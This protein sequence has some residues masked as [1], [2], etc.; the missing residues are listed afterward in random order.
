MEIHRHLYAVAG[1]CVLSVVATARSGH[2]PPGMHSEGRPPALAPE[3]RPPLSCV[4]VRTIVCGL[5]C[6]ILPDGLPST[7][8]AGESCS[9]NASIL[10]P[11]WLVEPC[12]YNSEIPRAR[13]TR[14]H[15][16]A[17]GE[18]LCAGFH[19]VLPSKKR[20]SG[21]LDTRRCWL[22]HSSPHSVPA[23]RSSRP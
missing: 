14:D 23:N 19:P 10:P 3:V 6:A 20:P 8:V 2:V 12:P 16:E 15:L 7:G 4:H 22:H 13:R 21:A 17:P 18:L 9:P 1:I 5:P 11:H